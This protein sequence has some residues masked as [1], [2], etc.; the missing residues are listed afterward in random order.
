ML[1]S[2]LLMFLVVLF[3]LLRFLS[4]FCF[5]FRALLVVVI[6]SI[7]FSFLFI[8]LFALP[9]FMASFF[10]SLLFS[11]FI[12]AYFYL[13]LIWR[14]IFIGILIERGE[15]ISFTNEIIILIFRQRLSFRWPFGTLFA[16]FFIFI[17]NIFVKISFFY[18]IFRCLFFNFGACLSFP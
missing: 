10:V 14:L 7:S 5:L 13:T 2:M 16:C 8:F 15:T 9:F 12:M 6:T 4:S 18:I 3:N 1:F 11:W 17:E